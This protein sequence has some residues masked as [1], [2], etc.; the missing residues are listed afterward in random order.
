[1]ALQPM[2]KKVI[3]LEDSRVVN[4]ETGEIVQETNTVTWQIPK[5]PNY[6]K[7]YLDQ[8]VVLADLNGWIAKILWELVQQ[9]G[10]ANEGQLIIINA[11]YKRLLSEKLGLKVQTITNAISELAKKRIILKKDRGLFLLNPQ[12][13]GKGDWA[14]VSKIRYQVELSAQGTFVQL[15]GIERN[16][17]DTEHSQAHEN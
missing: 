3:R 6:V 8:I 11:S 7:V 13:F 5:E 17:D 2:N 10:W 16:S 1:L 4:S 9:S 15:T 14:D 12:F